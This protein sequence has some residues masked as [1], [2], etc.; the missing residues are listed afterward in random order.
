MDQPRDLSPKNDCGAA[1]SRGD[2][3]LS[4][5]LSADLW[6]LVGSNLPDGLILFDDDGLIL[7]VNQI[8]QTVFGF[9]EEELVGQ[10]ISLLLPL[11]VDV[12]RLI[13]EGLSDH[14]D[15]EEIH[16][17]NKDG[18]P[19]VMET[20]VG[21]LPSNPQGPVWIAV[22]RTISFR[23]STE[24]LL[25]EAEKRLGSIT[26]NLPGVVF[27]RLMEPDGLIGYP[28]FAAGVYDILGFRPEEIQVNDEGCLSLVH[29]ADRDDHLRAI[30]QSAQ[31][32][33]P[34]IEEFRAISKD[35]NVLWLRGTSRPHVLHDGSVMWD[36]VLIDVS[37]RKRA[38][39]TLQMIMDHAADSIITINIEGSIESA[40]AAVEQL[41]GYTERELIGQPVSLLMPEPYRANHDLF[42]RR[43]LESGMG[44]IIGQGPRELTGQRKDGSTFPLE[45]ATSEVRLESRRLFI[46]IGR[47]VTKRKEA[48]E[49]LRFLAY[50]D[51]LTRAANRALFV[52]EMEKALGSGV[53]FAIL[54]LG[55]DR[56][57]MINSTLGHTVGDLV[58]QA[59]ADRMRENL[60]PKD[61]LARASGDRF[62]LL[63]AAQSDESE[64]LAAVDKLLLRLQDPMQIQGADFEITASVGLCLAPSDGDSGEVLVKNADAAL[65]RAKN[66]GPGS[67]RRFDPSM[68]EGA[69]KTLSLQHRMRRALDHHEFIPYFQPQVEL[70]EG[71]LVGMEALARWIS[72]DGMISPGEFIPVAEEYGL[73][74]AI[75]EQMLTACCRQMR[76]WLDEGLDVVPVAVNISGRQFQ[77]PKR[78]VKSLETIL[79]ETSLPPQLL[80]LELTESSAMSDPDAAIAVVK[81]LKDMGLA[82]AIDD[83]GT[84]YSSLSVLKRFPINK[85]KIDRSFVMDV[86]TD[87]NDATIV[88]AIIA[89]AHALKL[90]IV[91]EGVETI[92]HLEFLRGL[93][94]D[95]I[96]GYL[97]SRP[98]PAADMRA[99]LA[100]KRRM[101][102]PG[103]A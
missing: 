23:I 66:S 37:D 21:R 52:E 58:L 55:I 25:I 76:Q 36:G 18:R 50:Y 17:C 65:L 96:Q 35:G 20:A 92:D 95:Q 49:Q 64:T 84:G 19:V 61:F 87:S 14:P 62:L 8:T 16:F 42:M 48:E 15:P 34:C 57:S 101:K 53:P 68:N 81:R 11:G 30:R 44:Q 90:K 83:F 40:N 100:E 41:F 24:D 94:C 54:S 103:V 39:Q 91:A 78:L 51:P 12:R 99:M 5:G 71:R 63:L 22:L 28:F 6:R 9:S 47:D 86:T 93:K 2:D 10:S 33:T 1:L 97:F 67:I 38:E 31:S 26:S 69:I 46:G 85:L 4:P 82:S 75:S 72:P 102:I 32:L 77:Q 89:M 70:I 80:E 27:Q 56:L 7:A 3:R 73:I 43:F 88:N 98:L 59:A 74:D 79:T 29:W 60:G 45:L 13:G